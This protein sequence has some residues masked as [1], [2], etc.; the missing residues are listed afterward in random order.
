MKGLVGLLALGAIAP[1]VQAQA[2]TDPPPAPAP[3]Q[4]GKAAGTSVEEV[5]ITAR[6]PAS[7]TLIDRKVYSVT[8]DLQ[9]TSGTAADVLNSVPSVS[10]D[11]DGNLSLRGDANVTVLVDGKPSAQ[12]SGSARGLSLQQFPASEIDRIEVLASPPAQYKAEGSGGVINI[13]T[14]KTRRQ[15]YSGA[16]QLSVGDRRRF[17]LGVSGSY[18]AGPLKLSGALNLRQ[19]AR[20]RLTTSTRTATDPATNLGEFS[21]QSLDEH[22][23]R[24]V[25]SG[26]LAL[27]YDLNGRQS[28]GASFNHRELTGVRFFDQHDQS[29]PS[30]GA[31]TG[32]SDRHSD[33][34][35]W[36][37]DS[38]GEAHFEQKL[39]R[40]NET[41]TL[42]LQTS[43]DRERE[44]YAYRNTFTLP[45][46][47]PTFDNL[48]LSHDLIATEFSADYDLPLSH[49][50]EL[51][52]G[53]D[54]EDD[55]NRFDNVGDTIDPLSGL[56]VSNPAVTNHFRYRQQIHAA[57]GQY[58][59]PI[60][61]WS[62]QAGLRLEATHVSTLQITGNIPGG[63]DDVGV[64]PS[65][66]LDRS[67]GEDAKLSAS[68][69]RRT[70]RPDPEIL[71]PFIDHQD[72]HNLRAGNPDLLAQDTWSFELG[73]SATPAA[74]TYG[75]TAY[76]RQDRNGVTDILVPVTGDIVLATK[77]NLPLTRSAGVEFNANG[78]VGRKLT[79]AVSGDVFYKQIDAGALGA[80]G[81]KS[82][83]GLNLKASLTYQPTSLDTA[84]ISFTRQDRRL[85]P[86]GYLS[87]VNLVNLGYRRQLRPDLA[88]V[89]TVSDALDG[90]R[91]Q[92]LITT[93]VLNDD[94][95]R[96]QSGRVAYV[97]FV[98]TFGAQKKTKGNG[99]QYDP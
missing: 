85:T 24:L 1:A 96:H 64:Y 25:P 58:Q 79:Y 10:V 84:Q 39:W 63:R 16:V 65:L 18:N 67:L 59:A 30:A 80:G 37:L 33:G 51:K 38:G 31:V 74:W 8:S 87:A 44:R 3:A 9:A 88:L 97:G 69:T 49:D 70:T 89:V 82:T 28:F 46:S 23:R 4:A 42:T 72:T 77:A 6:Q 71:N 61:P 52:L 17:T 34:R 55:N 81:L 14:R 7:Q 15:G 50:R 12:F 27:D 90:Q 94:F 78:R 40:P 62:F 43:A 86:Q 13:I 66:H 19:D 76:Y 57:Y 98:Y 53:Y 60:G 47:A 36:S 21:H 68:I 22:F 95:E 83:T 99:F 48:R 41:L 29:G 92:R 75:A 11:A 93:P 26:N 32:V 35:E 45:V 56:P 73:Y 91:Q 54:F 2:Q 5:V 20:V